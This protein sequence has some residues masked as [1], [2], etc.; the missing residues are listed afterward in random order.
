MFTFMPAKLTLE[1]S[2][3]DHLWELRN[4]GISIRQLAKTYKITDRVITR[5]FDERGFWIRTKEDFFTEIDSEFKAY[6]LGF[7][8]ADGCIYKAKDKKSM[9]LSIFINEKDRQILDKLASFLNPFIKPICREIERENYISK[10]IQYAITNQR[11]AEDLIKWGILPRKSYENKSLLRFP[12]IKEEYKR[13]FIRGFF[14][15]DGEISRPTLKKNGRHV[16]FYSSSQLF[17]QDLQQELLNLGCSQGNIL[18]RKP[19]KK[20]DVNSTQDIYRLIY[21]TQKD[22]SK[23]NDI[24]Y[25]ESEDF[26]NRKKYFFDSVAVPVTFNHI[27]CPHCSSTAVGKGGVEKRQY[28]TQYRYRCKACKKSFTVRQESK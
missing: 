10:M 18:I 28:G 12:K 22:V 17:I 4:S 26:L 2:F 8:Y 19:K 15:G 25:T 9:T 21:W 13:H 20:K 5:H 14:D 6:I 24:F 23:I 27:S 11:I 16:S 1:T 7:I 3:V